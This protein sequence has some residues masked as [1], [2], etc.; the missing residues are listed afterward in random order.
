MMTVSQNSLPNPPDNEII[1]CTSYPNQPNQ[2]DLNPQS[3]F[4]TTQFTRSTKSMMLYDFPSQLGSTL[5][6]AAPQ[7]LTWPEPGL[8]SGVARPPLSFS[9]S[10]DPERS[11]PIAIAPTAPTVAPQAI[12]PFADLDADFDLVGLNALLALFDTP[13][14]ANRDLAPPIVIDWG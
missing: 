7:P 8:P 5:D 3:Q 9:R 1:A 13:T 4:T 6:T 14:A 11:S 10:A 12:D 2:L